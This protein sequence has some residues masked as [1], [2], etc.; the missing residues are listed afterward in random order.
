MIDLLTMM[1]VAITGA[2]RTK[3][4]SGGSGSPRRYYL[5]R[6]GTKERSQTWKEDKLRDK[7][8]NGLSATVAS[9]GDT[10]G[11]RVEGTDG[12][13]MA[14]TPVAA[15]A[16]WDGPRGGHEE[17]RLNRQKGSDCVDFSAEG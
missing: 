15:G 16:G 4:T 17:V 5:W 14:D 9:R 10:E 13:R 7:R 11:G 1:T 12:G 2:D 6:G 8:V 3:T